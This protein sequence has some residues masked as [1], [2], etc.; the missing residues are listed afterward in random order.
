[1]A[2]AHS[3]NGMELF[4][5]VA[6]PALMICAIADKQLFRYLS[7]AV[8]AIW[9]TGLIIKLGKSIVAKRKEKRKQ[10]PK[11]I[12]PE[13]KPLSDSESLFLYRQ[14]NCRIT[15]QLRTNYPD[16]SWLWVN[17]PEVEELAKGGTWRIR[18][19]NADPFN[20]GEVTM[21]DMAQISINLMQIL[22][23][24]E[25][26]ELS[27]ED[28]DLRQ[29][30]M[31]ERPDAEKWYLELGQDLLG[32]VIDDLNSQGHKKMLVR[33]DGGVC[34]QQNGIAQTIQTIRD[35]PPR[36]SWDKFCE[37]L[38]KDEIKAEPSAE[39]LQMSW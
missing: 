31:L 2:T 22:S 39:G 17:R 9:L 21:T 25:A 19:A 32:Q 34:V 24:K 26:A 14:I 29:E 11:Q 36:L 28:E 37:V 4:R 33:E 10:K 38:A 7:A 16:V 35:F 23:L 27:H 20:F 30:E 5:A 3:K 8:S 1:M 15:E 18:L 13:E 12:A 6:I